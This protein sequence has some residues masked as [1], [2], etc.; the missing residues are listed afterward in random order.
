LYSGD[1]GYRDEEG[2]FHLCGR[3]DDVINIGGRKVHP[4]EIEQALLGHEQIGDAVCVGTPDELTGEAVRAFLV[5]KRDHGELPSAE[6][7]ANFLRGR[8]EPYKIPVAFEWGSSIP[9]NASGK[10]ERKAVVG[11]RGRSAGRVEAGARR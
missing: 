4:A 8:L 3:E 11:L 10:V 1:L 2:Y 5:A 6:A 9:R 7:L